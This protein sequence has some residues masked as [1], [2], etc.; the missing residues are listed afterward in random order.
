[1]PGRRCVDWPAASD[2]DLRTALL[3]RN[4]V[5]E[6]HSSTLVMRRSMPSTRPGLRRG[7]SPTGTRRT[8]S[9]CC[10]PPRPG[11]IGVVREPL[12]R[13]PQGQPVVV[14]A[15]AR[16]TPRRR[17]STSWRSTPRSHRRRGA[18]P[19]S[20]ARSRSPRPRMGQRVAAPRIASQRP[21]PLSAGTARA[22]SRS[23]RPPPASTRAALLVPGAPVRPG[24]V[25]TVPA[26]GRLPNFLY[27][28]PGQGRLLVAARGAARATRRS[29]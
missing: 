3:L 14:P 17:W 12:A 8:T 6:L 9:S 27:I 16:R 15:S 20:W 11:R 25:M 7:R 18:T 2:L 19:G 26:V 21:V 4:R 24:P 23:S 28:G 13:H 29:T 1:M 5:K 10:A 22:R